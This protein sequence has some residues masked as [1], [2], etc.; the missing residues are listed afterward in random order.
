MEIHDS[1]GEVSKHIFCQEDK[2]PDINKQIDFMKE[3]RKKPV[4][5]TQVCDVEMI[6]AIEQSLIA[7]RV[8]LTLES[9]SNQ[10]PRWWATEFMHD[11]MLFK[12]NA[13]TDRMAGACMWF[14]LGLL[15][16]STLNVLIS[17]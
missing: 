13:N 9:K 10:K 14:I 7:A 3:L 1:I 2:L 12:S 17:L 16:C 11:C 4:N 8:L 6:F 5:K 15:V